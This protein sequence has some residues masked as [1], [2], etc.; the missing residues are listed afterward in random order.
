MAVDDP[1]EFLYHG[2]ASKYIPS[3]RHSGLLPQLRRYVHLTEY[4]DT[5]VKTGL[6]HGEPV[7][8]KVLSQAMGSDG[9]VFYRLDNG[10][11]LTKEV[12]IRYIVEPAPDR[13]AGLQVDL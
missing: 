5:A 4:M 8:L 10:V 11:W 7:L 3:I 2:T 1:P 12:P 13:A 9:Y 6:R